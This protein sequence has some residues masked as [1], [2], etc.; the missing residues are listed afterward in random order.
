[1]L[2]VGVEGAVL[3]QCE[4]RKEG[5]NEGRGSGEAE[6]SGEGLLREAF[7]LFGHFLRGQARYISGKCNAGLVYAGKWQ[8]FMLGHWAGFRFNRARKYFLFH[9]TFGVLQ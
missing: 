9:S 4:K 6:G 7:V 3:R 8:G 1:M 5:Q 2:V